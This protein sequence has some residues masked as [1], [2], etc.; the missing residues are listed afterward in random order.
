LYGCG[1]FITDYEGIGGYEQFRGELAIMYFAEV[2][3]Q[4]A[5][6]L[7]VR[8]IP[9]QVRRF[10][11]NRASRADAQWLCDLLSELGAPLGTSVRLEDHNSMMLGWPVRIRIEAADFI[12]STRPA[13]LSSHSPG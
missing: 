10:R 13:P 4:A 5:R 1:D 9:M 12:R 3:P 11:L 6:L 2:D 7:E 8:L